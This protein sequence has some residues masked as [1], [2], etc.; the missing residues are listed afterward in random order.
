MIELLATRTMSL[1]V[2][3]ASPIQCLPVDILWHIFEYVCFGD[4]LSGPLNVSQVSCGWRQVSLNYPFI[5]S[6]I[7]IRLNS[8]SATSPS[9]HL[10]ASAFFERSKNVPIGLYIYAARLFEPVE[11]N[12]MIEML[13]RN[14]RRFR[15]LY[16]I[17]NE[18]YLANQL[19]MEMGHIPMPNLEAFDT[20][21]SGTTSSSISLTTS[22]TNRMPTNPD[23]NV[24]IIPPVYFDDSLVYWNYWNPTGLTALTLDATGLWSPPDLDE[25]Y[26]V[27]ATTR[28]TLQNFRYQGPISSNS[29]E[30]NTRSRLEFPKLHSLA[31]LCHNNMAPLLW[32]MIIPTL[33]S[34]ILRDY[35]MYP[36]TIPIEVTNDDEPTLP[37]SYDNHGLIQNI[38]Q[39]TTVNH[40]E[41]Y[42]INNSDLQSDNLSELSSYVK[43]LKEL[44]S[45]VLY[46]IGVATSI[47]HSLFQEQHDQTE[48]ALLPKLSC[49]LL[50]V[51]VNMSHFFVS[52][53]SHRLPRLQK[54]I[55]NSEN[56][57]RMNCI[58]ILWKNCDNIFVIADPE[59]GEFNS[60][61]EVKLTRHE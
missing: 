45:L 36:A 49:L 5:W 12:I 34:L 43:S 16:I 27:L 1:Q 17:A 25:L 57:N 60:I 29:T 58:D 11:R 4:P 7:S 23:D 39:W 35:T 8:P 55:L 26:H 14:S 50:A 48:E 54:L 61:E 2:I 30:V 52:R 44:S 15:C 42:G 18:D 41:I 32:V 38:K 10:L 21:V 28:H 3:P 59:I 33:K 20:V 47:A 51:Q 22:R 40:L 19:W 9:K 37:I 24:N 56:V 31:L 46:G 53:Q 13:L 6:K